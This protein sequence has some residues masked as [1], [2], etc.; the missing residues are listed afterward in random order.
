MLFKTKKTAAPQLQQS[1]REAIVDLLHLCL[2]SDAHISLKE[3]EFIADVVNVIGW[4]TNLSFSSYESRSIAA[5]RAARAEE[6][7]K[8]EFVAY[9][10]ERLKS[11]ANRELAL[12][13]CRDLAASDGTS[14]S[15][16]TLIALIRSVF[17]TGK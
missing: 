2:F 15:E 9:A 17:S 14:S 10:A 6:K 3:G 11:P 4:D 13:L 16:G 1:E 12:S 8:R 5:A 7:A